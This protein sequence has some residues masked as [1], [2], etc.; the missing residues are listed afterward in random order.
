MKLCLDK[1]GF[2]GALIMNL[3]EVFHTIIHKKL[4]AMMHAYGCSIEALEVLL[5]YLQ[6]KV[7]KNQDQYNF[8]FLDSVTWRSSARIGS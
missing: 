1:Q 5:S 6:Q 7:A 3:H 4:L 8:Q 2:A